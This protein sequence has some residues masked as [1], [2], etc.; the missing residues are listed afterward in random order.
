MPGQSD[1]LGPQWG[2]FLEEV[3]AGLPETVVLHCLGGFVAAHYGL[4]RPT[5][6]LDYI[7]IAP[8]SAHVALSR[9]AGEG[10]ELSRKHGLCFQYVVGASIPESYEERLVELFAGRFTRLRLF[11]LE[12]H[13]LALS[14]LARNVAVDREDV[15]F[16][17]RAV[18]LDAEVFRQRYDVEVRPIILGDVAVHDRTVRMWIDSYFSSRG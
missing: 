12:P 18:P 2:K 4:P 1:A 8:S 6:D 15:E 13:D 3:D 5:G 9:L 16:L 14:K 17:A 10:S 7:E 11:A